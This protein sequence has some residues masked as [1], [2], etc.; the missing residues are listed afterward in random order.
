MNKAMTK[1][2]AYWESQYN[3]RAA[4]PPIGDVKAMSAH[5]AVRNPGHGRAILVR[6][7]RMGNQKHTLSANSQS[8]NPDRS[9]RNY[10]TEAI[11]LMGSALG[12]PERKRTGTRKTICLLPPHTQ[13]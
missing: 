6:E 8:S 4:V 3:N 13:S 5:L 7:D 12:L 9:S 11:Y 2:A 1:D 10:R